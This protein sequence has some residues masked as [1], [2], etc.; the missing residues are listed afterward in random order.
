MVGK[1][2]TSDDTAAKM[3]VPMRF[4]GG[5]D[6]GIVPAELYNNASVKA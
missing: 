2:T 4:I 5:R 1:F 6:N 3:A